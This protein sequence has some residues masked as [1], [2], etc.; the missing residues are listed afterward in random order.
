MLRKVPPLEMVEM[1]VVV[2]RTSSFRAAARS[3][4]LSPSAVS[5]RIAGL[6]QSLGIEL[7]DR[8]GQSVALNAAG[9]RYLDLIEPAISAIR[10]AGRTIAGE[11]VAAL[12]IAAS[13]SL[14]SCW[15]E[16]RIAA[17]RLHCGVNIEILV[18]RD[19]AALRAGE[20]DLA[21]WGGL[22][23]ISGLNSNVLFE[24]DALPV[25]SPDAIDGRKTP[26]REEE[27][28]RLSL[29]G[30]GSPAGLWE[31]W[32]A[33]GGYRPPALTVRELPSVRKA[34]E[35]AATGLGATLAVPLL[36]EQA[37]KEHK[38]IPIARWRRI[39]EAYRLYRAERP[40]TAL[41]H[42]FVDW[43][44]GEM[45]AS[46]R[47]IRSRRRALTIRPISM[48]GFQRNAEPLPAV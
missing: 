4:A 18:S 21:M 14:A 47:D 31:R 48:L 22:G 23:E 44:H 37:L 46:C 12:R 28:A 40:A 3:M 41:Q 27:L 24:V 11:G 19:P 39:G 35:T 16:P 2:A 7:F 42:R 8:C 43:L 34:Y 26:L 1:F 6:E 25:A 13:D 10:D 32:F 20:T 15:L 29:L 30:V 9:R 38:L 45:D 17:A 36:S 5:R 33:L